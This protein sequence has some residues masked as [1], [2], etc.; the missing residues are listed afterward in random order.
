[1]M[2][3][4]EESWSQMRAA[5]G[6]VLYQ[7]PRRPVEDYFLHGTHHSGHQGVEPPLTPSRIAQRAEKVLKDQ[8]R[9]FR[10]DTENDLTS[11]RKSIPDPEPKYLMDNKRE[12][13]SELFERAK[14]QNIIAVLDTGI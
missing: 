12:Y 10:A 2:K 5:P 7:N 6:N 1:M 4:V 11:L 9:G 3:T 8:A 13:Q 14:K